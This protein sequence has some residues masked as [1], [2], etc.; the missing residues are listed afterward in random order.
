MPQ[1]PFQ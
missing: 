1:Q